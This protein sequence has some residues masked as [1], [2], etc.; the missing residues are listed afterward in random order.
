[1]EKAKTV[2][3]RI[4]VKAWSVLRTAVED[5]V[6]LGWYRAH[7]QSPTPDPESAKEAIE[8]AVIA[9]ISEWFIFDE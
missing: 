8:E 4:R 9:S 2:S 1:M 3:G 6:S 7:N 5:G